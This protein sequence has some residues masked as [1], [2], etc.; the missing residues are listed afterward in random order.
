MTNNNVPANVPLTDANVF[1]NSSLKQNNFGF[2]VSGIYQSGGVYRATVTINYYNH[3][4]VTP[5]KASNVNYSVYLIPIKFKVL[6]TNRNV[7][8]NGVTE[9]SKTGY[10]KTGENTTTTW[11]HRIPTY[12]WS[13]ETSLAGY[14][15]TGIYED[16]AA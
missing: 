8:I 3:N 4:G 6:Y 2:D 9:S 13:K 11:M 7:C 10:T 1:K 15:Y 14:E 5:Y 16:R 12:T